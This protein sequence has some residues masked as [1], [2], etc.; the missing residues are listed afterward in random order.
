MIRLV[1]IVVGG[2]VV[3]RQL[4]MGWAEWVAERALRGGR[5]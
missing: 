5:W 4:V 3:G 1:A 2:V